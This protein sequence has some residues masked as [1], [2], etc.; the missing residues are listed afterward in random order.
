MSTAGFSG[1]ALTV[2]LDGTIIAA[3]QS[4]STSM[5]RAPIDTT[6]DDN[7]GWRQLLPE[8][9]SRSVDVPIDGVA[10]SDNYQLILDEWSG[11]LL[12]AIVI[13][14]PD[15]S[16][17]TA[18][19]GFF[20]ASLEFSGSNDGHVAFSASLQSSGEVTITGPV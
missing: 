7:N 17:M 15:G 5:N 19:D 2:E 20:L 11:N 12:S 13:N 10:T 14:N 4:K 6:N 1:R 16:T 3:I 8:P 9:A 18:A